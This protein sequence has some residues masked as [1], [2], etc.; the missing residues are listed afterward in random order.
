MFKWRLNVFCMEKEGDRQADA[1]T[2][3]FESAEFPG[4]SAANTSP[5]SVYRCHVDTQSQHIDW[6]TTQVEPAIEASRPLAHGG[7]LPHHANVRAR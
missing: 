1:L 7:I 5:L 3:A 6:K 4:C 2:H